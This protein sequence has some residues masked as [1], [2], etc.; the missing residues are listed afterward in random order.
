MSPNADFCTEMEAD[1]SFYYINAVPQWQPY[2]GGNWAV[3]KSKKYQV[4]IK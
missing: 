3:S 1:A 2:N 4:I